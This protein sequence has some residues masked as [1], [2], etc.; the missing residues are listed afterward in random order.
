MDTSRLAE[1][2]T[3]NLQDLEFNEEALA[4]NQLPKKTEMIASEKAHILKDDTDVLQLSIY[5]ARKGQFPQIFP[6]T[7]ILKR[8]HQNQGG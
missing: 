3:N 6:S 8:S 5:Q 4:S 7:A 2:D 1:S